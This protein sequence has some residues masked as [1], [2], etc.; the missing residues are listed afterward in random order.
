M[1]AVIPPVDQS[2][3]PTDQQSQVRRQLFAMLNGQGWHPPAM[4][5]VLPNVW[6]A[7]RKE[8]SDLPEASPG[9]AEGLFRQILRVTHGNDEQRWPERYRQLLGLL[10]PAPAPAGG[11]GNPP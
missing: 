5:R 4:P 8:K 3:R 2:S 10:A 6:K 1:I 11:T 9:S 7:A